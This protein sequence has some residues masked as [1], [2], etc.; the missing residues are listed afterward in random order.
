MKKIKKI[1][2]ITVLVTIVCTAWSYAELYQRA[3]YTLPGTLPEMRNPSYWIDRMKNPDEVILTP[4]AIKAMNESYKKRMKAPD[5]FK[6]VDPDFLPNMDE[7]HRWL[8]RF[9][10]M[11]D[12]YNMTPAQIADIV[13]EEISN[14]IDFMTGKYSRL[15][16]GIEELGR[17]FGNSLGVEY[18]DRDLD[19]L[20]KEMALDFVRDDITIL[21]G[22]TICDARLRVVPTI[23]VEQIG[24]IENGKF[25]WDLWNTNIIRIGTPVTVLH[26]SKTG[27]YLFVLSNAGYGW[28]RSENIAFGK[29][30]EI[31]KFREPADFAV[32]TGDF[33]PF[34]SDESCRYVSGWF[35]MGDR[36][37][38]ASED[39]PGMINAP[40]RKMNGQFEIEQAWLAKDA[41]VHVGY[42]PYTRRNIVE[43]ALKLLDNPYDLS[44][45]WYGRNHETTDIDIFACFGFELPL[46]AELFSFYG[47][48][49]RVVHPEVGREEQYKAILAND[50]FVTILNCST[51]HNQLFLG[52][53]NGVPIVLD[54]LGYGYT[55][56]NGKTV[57]ISRCCISDVSR[58]AYILETNITFLE[59]K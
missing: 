36:L 46:Y 15:H 9:I 17:K 29:K 40:V 21:E 47:S 42:L 35:R 41:D 13:R 33:V 20:K 51:G 45:A 58:P 54:Q 34:Y 6:G 32:C 57:E 3:P 39:N 38:L 27:A 14:E 30:A 2:L 16:L 26:T 12:I 53:Y 44:M 22:I 25:R 48:D 52:E 10:T 49:T 1:I 23:R 8:G 59:L 5:P 31:K 56:N 43:T 55:D 18:S 24:L 28:V 19:D 11:P 7:L 4:T 50:P 37:P